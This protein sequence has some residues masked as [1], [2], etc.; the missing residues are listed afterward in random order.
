MSVQYFSDSKPE[1]TS[2]VALI[3]YGGHFPAGSSWKCFEHFH[4][5]YESKKFQMFDYGSEGANN[6]Y[7]GQPT[8]P[9]YPT[10][11]IEGFKIVLIVGDTD[12]LATP[13][14]AEEIK[15]LLE[16]Q[17]SLL[18][19]VLTPHGHMGLLSPAKGHEEHVTEMIELLNEHNDKGV[20]VE[21]AAD[22]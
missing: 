13:E 16:G 14:D 5:L 1:L 10:S 17:N 6:Q 22:E 2:S 20:Q 18:K 12:L 19:H 15:T 7:Y 4:Q 8:P 11:K 21:I 3:N 9:E